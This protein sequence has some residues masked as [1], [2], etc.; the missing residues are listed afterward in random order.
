MI[1]TLPATRN[2]R[3]EELRKHI[4]LDPSW[5]CSKVLGRE[6]WS[7]QREILESAFNNPR[8]AVS[9]CVSSSKTH[10][11]AS[12]VFA[13]LFGWGPGSRVFT[14]AP[15]FRQVDLNLWGEIPRAHAAARNLLGGKLFL[16]ARYELAQDWFAQGFSTKEPEFVHGIH[17]P[18]DLLIIDDAHAVPEEMFDELENMEAGGDTHIVLLFNPSRLS[19]TTYNCKHALRS[20][21]HNI[22]IAYSDTP[23]AKAGKNIVKGMLKPETVARWIA[24]YGNDSNF[25]R[26]KVHDLEPKQEADTLIPLEWLELA[27]ARVV[28]AAD[29]DSPCAYGQDVARFGDDDSARCKILGRSVVSLTSFNGHDTMRTTGEIIDAQRERAGACA[30]DVIG[31]GSGVVDRLMELDA[32]VIAVNVSEKSLVVDETGREMFPNLRSELWWG[33][34]EAL[35]PENPE[36]LSLAGLDEVIAGELIAELS[37]VRYKIDSAGRKVVEPK[38][39]MKKRLGGSPD[40]ADSFCLAVHAL[41]QGAGGGGYLNV[42]EG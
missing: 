17:G 15:S 3:G 42:V 38:D 2:L 33:A 11:A 32:E 23:N 26:V 21:W 27:R 30:V 18:H 20:N 14:L 24:R 25:V 22:G 34:R 37:S 39:A 9:G 29:S 28:P 40:K 5:F 4:R 8:T 1:A 10:A 13:W 7:K 35:N 31:I 36:A 41:A 16:T 6:P 19:G 12:L